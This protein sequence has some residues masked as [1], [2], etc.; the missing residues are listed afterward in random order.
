MSDSRI[1]QLEYELARLK[2]ELT[3]V[4]RIAQEALTLAKRATRPSS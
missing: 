1:H 3:E 4:K 2:S